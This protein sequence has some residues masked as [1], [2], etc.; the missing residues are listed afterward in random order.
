MNWL[1][2]AM[3]ETLTGLIERV[4]YHNPE[5]GRTLRRERFE[6]KQAVRL[7]GTSTRCT[8]TH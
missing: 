1:I 3:A 8:R 2:A 4:T 6:L 7:I 5:N